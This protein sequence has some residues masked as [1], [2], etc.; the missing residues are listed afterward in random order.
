[1]S[2]YNK[3]TERVNTRTNIDQSMTRRSLVVLLGF[4]ET[5]LGFRFIFKL[6][7]A[8]PSNVFINIL[9]K[10]T[11]FI[12]RMFATIFSPATTDGLETVSV[13][14]PGTLIAMFVIALIAVA[15]SKLMDQN[16]R[17]QRNTSETIQDHSAVNRAD[18]SHD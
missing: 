18:K 14:E 17:V 8:N 15:I 10:S 2:D 13:F 12:V 9:Y 1:M 4:I 3:T 7:G 6:M 5:V 11:E 16:T